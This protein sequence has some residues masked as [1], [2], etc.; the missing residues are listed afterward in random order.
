MRGAAR[1]WLSAA[2]VEQ[3]QHAQRCRAADSRRAAD[4]PP[5]KVRDLF[6][7]P[8]SHAG[9]PDLAAR[10]AA[11]P[12]H[13]TAPCSPRSATARRRECAPS[14]VPRTTY[15]PWPVLAAQRH[16]WR[17]QASQHGTTRGCA[18]AR[19]AHARA[20]TIPVWSHAMIVRYCNLSKR[21]IALISHP[22][23]PAYLG[24]HCV[25]SSK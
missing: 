1:A 22:T 8:C 11:A 7:R 25:V 18:T 16:S 2:M 4:V 12:P 10:D 13:A 9:R 14:S 3:W 23:P 20:G 19:A 5:P 17:M 15:A 6:P 24:L 21:G